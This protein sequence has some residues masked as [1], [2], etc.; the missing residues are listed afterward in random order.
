[1]RTHGW[2]GHPPADDDEARNRILQAARRCF[3]EKGADTGI[4]DV[5][6]AVGVTRQTVYRYFPSTEHLLIATAVGATGPF[7]ERLAAHNAA[8][9]DPQEAVIEA[10]AYTLEQL[11][12]ESYLSLVLSAGQVSTFAVGV[13]SE[14]AMAFGRSI[15]ERFPVDWTAAGYDGQL[16]A[17]L[18]EHLLRTIQSFVLDPG[19]PPRAGQELRGYLA[20]WIA[21]SVARQDR[22]LR[23]S[24]A[25][26]AGVTP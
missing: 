12:S 11:P 18:V 15:L 9:S 14:T 10:I 1:M 26:P 4:A 3:D 22:G 19:R 8:I 24:P 7:L 16:L 13:T 21:P 23:A 25:A 17:E 5:A 20:R 6:R 2:A